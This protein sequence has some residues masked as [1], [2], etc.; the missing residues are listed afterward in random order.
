MNQLIILSQKRFFKIY[1]PQEANLNNPDQNIDFIFAENNKYHQI[2]NA[3]LQYD[4]TIR[5]TVEIPEFI[6]NHTVRLVVNA[7]AYRFKNLVWLRQVF[8]N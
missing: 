2:G 7:S 5:K 3:Y 4:I 6:D 1:H 8:L